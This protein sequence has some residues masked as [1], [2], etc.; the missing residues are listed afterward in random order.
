MAVEA[1][2]ER[3]YFLC[4]WY[5]SQGVMIRDAPRGTGYASGRLPYQCLKIL[6]V[7]PST[8]NAP[9]SQS[10]WYNGLRIELQQ[11]KPDVIC[12]RRNVTYSQEVRPWQVRNAHYIKNKVGV[13][14]TQVCQCM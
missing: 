2:Q 14:Y 9:L 8:I 5:K 3:V 4:Q 6:N 11:A 7:C 12:T 13:M 10:T 1:E